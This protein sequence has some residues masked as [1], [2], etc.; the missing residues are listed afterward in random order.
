LFLGGFGG[1]LSVFWLEIGFVFMCCSIL[2]EDLY[3]SAGYIA[4]LDMSEKGHIVYT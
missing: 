2:R 3:V 4:I 1:F